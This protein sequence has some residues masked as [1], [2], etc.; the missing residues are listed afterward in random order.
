M[1][2]T[3]VSLLLAAGRLGSI[4]G[5]VLSGMLYDRFGGMW[6]ARMLMLSVVA[7]GIPMLLIPG[8]GGLVLFVPFVA[9]SASVFPIANTLLVAA[10]PPRS[11]WG[12]G[13]FRSVMLG[14]SALL[15]GAVSVLLHYVSVPA[16]MLGAL[17]VPALAALV[18]H[19]VMRSAP[20]EP[21]RSEL[22]EVL[23]GGGDVRTQEVSSKPRVAFGD[24]VAD[25]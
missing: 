10:L 14:V 24:G 19:Q 17:V 22:G 21:P 4:P 1:S 2:L 6:V 16:V 25:G 12:I 9:I 15:S 3:L 23:D 20:A 8:A 13:T 7:L 5:K 18:I 11:A